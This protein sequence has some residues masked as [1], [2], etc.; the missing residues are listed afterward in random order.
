MYQY[1]EKDQQFIEQRAAQ[2]R[3]QTARF[4]SGDLIEDDYRPLRLM[5]GLY[6]QKHAPMLRI[7]VPYGLLN[8][9]QLRKIAHIART[10]DRGYAHVSTRQNFQFNWPPLETV[11]DILDELATVQM[12]AIQ[13]S[14]NCMRNVTSD[15]FA[16]IA[17]DELE[18]PRPY[19]EITRQWTSLHPE[20]AYLPRKFKIA[21]IGAA[22]DRAV[23][24]VHDL[25]L[26]LVRNDAGEI[27]FKVFVGGGL[28][29]TPIVAQVLRDYLPKRDMLSYMEAVLRIYNQIGRR[30]NKYKARI[31]ILVKQFGLE[32]FKAL[33]EA[34]W[35]RIKDGP[36]AV[37]EQTIDAMKA[38]FTPPDYDPA[39]AQQLDPKAGIDD[40]AFATWLEHNVVEHKVA[41]YS[42]A[43][44]SLKAK[45]IAP[46]DMT[47][48]QIDMVADLADRYSFGLAR[49]THD[50]NMLLGDVKNSDL[51]ALW[52][53]LTAAGLATANIGTVDDM[54]CCP[55]G[56]FCALANAAS[57][58]VAKE[59]SER[60]NDQHDLYDLG[61]IRIKISGCMNGCG[62]HDI[63]HIGIL[64]VDKKGSEWYQITLGGRGG[65]ATRLG[66]RLGR[67][68]ARE[69][70]AEAVETIIQ[71]YL[72]QR[73]AGE[74]F[75]DT[76]DRVGNEPFK[77]R[78][79][80]AG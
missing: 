48:A 78:V 79:Y 13:T 12:H 30:D 3:G 31:K 57:I 73:Q 75:L 27:G 6:V 37:S 68:L 1:D 80:A 69:K 71:V 9:K 39:A 29:R 55:G 74:S 33:V 43:Y 47:D 54:I 22:E 10:Y 2:F 52:Q 76:H 16:G 63:G 51:Y 32:P 67:A 66:Q 70:I 15:H 77:E 50:Q 56:E 26:R 64:G 7:A 8:S 58:P 44:I 38:H 24:Q 17:K 28:G 45:G 14:G 60:I 41:G 20:F 53:A 5:N 18:D 65:N 49:T 34:E 25:A 46:G 42:A 40:A 36:L 21:I 19:C 61:D 35:Q 72:D 23:I 62:H 4:L 59:I 11:P